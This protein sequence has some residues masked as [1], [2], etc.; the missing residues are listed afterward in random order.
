MF[1]KKASDVLLYMLLGIKQG[2]RKHEKAEEERV[3]LL[4]RRAG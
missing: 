3:A 1:A 2:L 4:I